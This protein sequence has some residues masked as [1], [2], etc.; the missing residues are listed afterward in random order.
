MSS[1]AYLFEQN[2]QF[3]SSL[4]SP[5]VPT[6]NCLQTQVARPLRFSTCKQLQRYNSTC[7]LLSNIK[8]S[9][10][11]R[12]YEEDIWGLDTF[13]RFGGWRQPSHMDQ[14]DCCG[15]CSVD[16]RSWSMD[17]GHGEKGVVVCGLEGG[18]DGWKGSRMRGT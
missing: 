4:P 8:V 11:K 9:K 12:I 2:A 10:L 18:E 3:L 1:D 13:W 14:C 17:D 6:D 5:P 16:A 15:Q 7:E